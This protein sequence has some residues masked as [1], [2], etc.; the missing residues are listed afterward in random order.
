MRYTLDEITSS[1]QNAR[2]TSSS[3]GWVIS[4][5]TPAL[6]IAPFQIAWATLSVS[7]LI[8]ASRVSNPYSA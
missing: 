8:F 1:P 4:E 6:C 2:A 3:F 5:N 7:R